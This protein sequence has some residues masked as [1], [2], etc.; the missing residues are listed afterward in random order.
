MQLFRF[1]PSSSCSSQVHSLSLAVILKP[2]LKEGE[3]W[4]RDVT[5]SEALGW[6][7]SLVL[8]GGGSRGHPSCVHL[9]RED[10][11]TSA[12]GCSI[13]FAVKEK[14]KRRK[15]LLMRLNYWVIVIQYLKPKFHNCLVISAFMFFVSIM[16]AAHLVIMK[17]WKV[18]S[19]AHPRF[20][21]SP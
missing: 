18:L 20:S 17:Y 6:D 1:I 7:G 12:E 10:S 19:N 16:Q 4:R 8:W 3:A 14:K 15:K 11:H 21:M 9:A 13:Y 2:P 5:G